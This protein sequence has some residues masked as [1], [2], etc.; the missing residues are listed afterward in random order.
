MELLGPEDSNIICPLPLNPFGS[1]SCIFHL[2]L[3]TAHSGNPPSQSGELGKKEARIRTEHHG[4]SEPKTKY[5]SCP[6]R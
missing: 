5:P 4:I 6:S 1:S 3:H 2:H